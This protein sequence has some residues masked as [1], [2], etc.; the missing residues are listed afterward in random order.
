MNLNGC[1]DPSSGHPP[2][3]QSV[4]HG[5]TFG[6]FRTPQNCSLSP[7]Y[8]KHLHSS[9]TL[10]TI[11]LCQDIIMDDKIYSKGAIEKFTTENLFFKDAKL[12]KY[13]DRNVQRDFGKF[14]DRVKSAHTTKDFEKIMYVFV[15]D[16]IR[17]I[18]LDTI[19]ELTQFLS[20]SG[21][22][23][24]SGGE[25]FNL[26]VEFNDR[27][28]T[29]DIDAKFVPRI[30]MNDKY[31]GKLQAVKLTLWN[32]L[33]ELAKRLNLRIKKRLLSMQKTHPKLFKFLGIGFK[34]SGPFVTRRYSLI[35]KKKIAANNRPSKGDIFI[36]VELF[37]LDLN[38][39]FFS[40]KT[41]KIEDLNMG[42][43]LDIPFMRP[44]EFGYEV[45]LTKKRG[46]TY[47][48]V[49]T[50]KLVNNK[51]I[52]VASKEF[53]IEDIFLMHKLRLRPEK[54]EK[55]RQRLIRLSQLFDKRIKASD[56][57]ED[58]FKKIIPK[59]KSKKRVT[60]KPVN[61]SVSKAAKIDPYKYKNF[62][63]KP[64][65]ERLSKQIVHGLKPVVKNTKV[66]GYITSSGNQRFNVKNL[67]WKDVTNTAYVKN[68]YALRPVNAKPLPKGMNT[69]KTLYGY[70]PRR[71]KWVPKTLL[72]RAAEI[73]FV[74]LKK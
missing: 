54:A 60:L 50:G 16:S 46:I 4:G 73:P 1:L 69:S 49:D 57:M 39:R 68:E 65:D 72:N 37:A 38:I 45:A 63:T 29:S 21:D 10:H 40:P 62:T 31:F 23:I 71:N 53:L 36:D 8:E 43:I 5:T 74:G 33:G 30:P 52:L 15:T 44:Q 48:S 25:A 26:Y 13:Y 51:R 59:I 9:I 20:S 7:V 70:N 28:I 12:K 34:Q 55:D 35:K 17:D 2:A 14:R 22:L 42:G 24:V 61:V 41:G 11:L 56:S 6:P 3:Q 66:N 27:I 58:A 19:G 18:I 67:R 64:S 32:K 47:H